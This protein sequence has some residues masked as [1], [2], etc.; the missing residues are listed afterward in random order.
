M[1]LNIS[2]NIHFISINK[3]EDKNRGNYFFRPKVQSVLP[4]AH[5]ISDYKFQVNIFE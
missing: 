2:M 3:Q 4:V 1:N 5:R